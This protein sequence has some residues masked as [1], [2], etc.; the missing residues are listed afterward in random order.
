MSWVWSLEVGLGVHI[1]VSRG[2]F[3]CPVTGLVR[4]VFVLWVWY[5][6]TG[7]GVLCL[8]SC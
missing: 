2:W 6:E 4:L 7:P 1:L 8:V 5:H 3:R